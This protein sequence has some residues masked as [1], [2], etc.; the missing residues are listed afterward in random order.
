MNTPDNLNPYRYVSGMTRR[1]SLKWLGLLAA[2]SALTVTAG[3]SKVV[4]ETIT[5]NAGH[6]PDVDIKP[7]T[8]KGYGTDPNMVIPPESPCH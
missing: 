5:P 8:A 3:C 1:E 7:V 6:W 2:G 4:E